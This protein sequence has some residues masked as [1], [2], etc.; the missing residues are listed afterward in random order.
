MIADLFLLT[1]IA[2]LQSLLQ[3]GLDL[4]WKFRSPLAPHQNHLPT[5]SQQMGR[6][7]GA[8][9]LLRALTRWVAHTLTDNRLLSGRERLRQRWR[10][11]CLR[12]FSQVA[13]YA[14]FPSLASWCSSTCPSLAQLHHPSSCGLSRGLKQPRSVEFQSQ[15]TFVPLPEMVVE[16]EDS[17][18]SLNLIWRYHPEDGSDTR[19]WS[20][21]CLSCLIPSPF[22]EQIG[23][24]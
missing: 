12:T 20:L 1:T 24:R 16:P 11:S 6:Y 21:A 3:N 15:V 22:S 13:I 7:Q 18:W 23:L 10:L 19:F 8:K 9:Q 17:K 14:A 2:Q 4:A 5:A